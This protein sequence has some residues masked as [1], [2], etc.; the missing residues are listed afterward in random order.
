MNYVSFVCETCDSQIK[1]ESMQDFCDLGNTGLGSESPYKQNAQNWGGGIKLKRDIKQRGI[2]K[3][4][5]PQ[6]CIWAFIFKPEA[7]ANE[8]L[9]N[10]R[11]C[12]SDLWCYES[13]PNIMPHQR[14][15]RP[16]FICLTHSLHS[17]IFIWT[18]KGPPTLHFM[19]HIVL[20]PDEKM[21]SACWLN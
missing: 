15:S 2:T 6:Q 4:K 17:A 9:E 7:E 1:A 16:S 13:L 5:Q 8:N 10:G 12:S 14:Q 19:H 21:Y 20:S 11:L 18:N 3:S